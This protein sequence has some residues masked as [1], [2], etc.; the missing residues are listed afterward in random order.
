M[1]IHY[2]KCSKPAEEKAKEDAKIRDIVEQTLGDIEARGDEAVH[3]LAVDAD[4]V[5]ETL[6][7]FDELFHRHRRSAVGVGLDDLGSVFFF[8]ALQGHGVEHGR[9]DDADEAGEMDH[10]VGLGF[11]DD[12][13]DHIDQSLGIGRVGQVGICLAQK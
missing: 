11:G 4:G 8:L 1:A 6:M 9:D 2:L 13:A 3:D 7:T 5:E 12:K 10:H